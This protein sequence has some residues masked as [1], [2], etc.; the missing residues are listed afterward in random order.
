[1]R[2]ARLAWLVLLVACGDSDPSD[3]V[4]SGAGA[5][6]SAAVGGIGGSPDAGG[7]AGSGNADAGGAGGDSGISV[8]AGLAGTGG[9]P[10]L[11][12]LPN[13]CESDDDCKL[14][15]DCC[16][17]GSVPKD[18]DVPSCDAACAEDRCA[19]L[20][21][22]A[23]CAHGRCVFDATCDDSKVTCKR[24]RPECPTG[25]QAIVQDGCWSDCVDA[26]ECDGVTSC[27][28]CTDDQA[29]V[30]P[31]AMTP[32]GLHCWDVPPAC[33]GTASCECLGN[34]VCDFSCS[35]EPQP[36]DAGAIQLGCF[37]VLC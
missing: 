30:A 20:G 4:D 35:D 24:T 16:S 29:C 13:E 10:A 32:L 9:S 7:A 27:D 2:V 34:D 1:M 28:A 15:G 33:N 26:R 18:A 36:P 12:A 14:V 19:Q 31:G 3:N 21:V 22:S 25:Q 37:C 8:D 6:A 17:C 11:P 5:G 23:V